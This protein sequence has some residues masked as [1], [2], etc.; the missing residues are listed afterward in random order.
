MRMTKEKV[1][2]SQFEKQYECTRLVYLQIVSLFL[3][4]SFFINFSKT[5]G[6]ACF[7][8]KLMPIR[9]LKSLSPDNQ[10][11]RQ[12]ANE[13]IS[14]VGVLRHWN[15]YDERGFPYDDPISHKK[16]LCSGIRVA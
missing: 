7:L 15:H 9:K 13:S 10:N 4:L 3:H 16:A 12:E 14:T 2:S 5:Y 8:P 11:R 6:L 1:I